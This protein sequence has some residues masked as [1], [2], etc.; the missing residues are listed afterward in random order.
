M[1]LRW[2]NY[3]YK[4]T[5]VWRQKRVLSQAFCGGVRELGLTLRLQLASGTSAS[6]P[7]LR[8]DSGRNALRLSVH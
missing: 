4:C 7:N 8:Q 6:N 3:E 5:L 2:L 1:F